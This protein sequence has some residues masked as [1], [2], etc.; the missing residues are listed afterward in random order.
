MSSLNES[1]L[2]LLRK[3]PSPSL[4]TEVANFWMWRGATFDLNNNFWLDF[5]TARVYVASKQVRPVKPLGTCK[6]INI[7]N[8]FGLG[9]ATIWK[10]K[11]KIGSKD[12]FRKN[13]N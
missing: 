13:E 10:A 8:K 2:L 11:L 1:V 5:L 7:S 4:P 9:R 3:Q 6:L 12:F